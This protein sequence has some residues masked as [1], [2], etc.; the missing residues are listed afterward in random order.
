MLGSGQLRAAGKPSK[1]MGGFA[2]HLF[3]GLPSRPGAA[4]TPEIG[5]FRSVK[6]SYVQNISTRHMHRNFLAKLLLRSSQNTA[7]CRRWHCELLLSS[8][9]TLGA[10]PYTANPA[11]RRRPE[12][13]GKVSSDF[14]QSFIMEVFFIICVFV[15]CFR[16]NVS[17]LFCSSNV[18]SSF[19][20]LFI[21]SV[22]HRLR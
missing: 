18:S 15:E 9:F 10:L 3:G 4:Q 17:F 6:K 5:D 14:H 13:A 21:T 8:I 12:A 11:L 1:K 20:Q 22:F 16:R 2:H 7:S 19:H